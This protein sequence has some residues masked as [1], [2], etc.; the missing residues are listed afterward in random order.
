MKAP[1]QAV[2]L[3][4]LSALPK[5]KSAQ[6]KPPLSTTIQR[7]HKQQGHFRNV[8]EAALLE[9][10]RANTETAAAAERRQQEEREKQDEDGRAGS[11]DVSGASGRGK[12]G[13]VDEDGGGDDEPAKKP[14]L[15][16]GDEAA[17]RELL[18]SAK[19]EILKQVGYVCVPARLSVYRVHIKNRPSCLILA[20]HLFSIFR[21]ALAS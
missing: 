8:T 1:A 5:A 3:I 4:P 7:I 13:R 9:Q 17:R 12:R 15:E 2:P 19:E 21:G 10:I 14:T 18:R 6:Q 11:N 16:A 20:C